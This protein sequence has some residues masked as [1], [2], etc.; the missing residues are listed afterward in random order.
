MLK[1]TTLYTVLLGSLLIP[2]LSF[3]ADD[4]VEDIHQLTLQWT[5][6]EH[7]KDLLRKNWRGDKPVLEQQLSLL[8]RET[9]AQAGHPV[10]RGDERVGPPSAA[11][12]A[13]QPRGGM[14]RG[15]TPARWS[16]LAASPLRA[17]LGRAPGG[18]A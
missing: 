6:L 18:T 10:R 12:N 5:G 3:G 16:R 8:E 4:P 7:Q 13:N 14:A 15:L 11:P 9:R 2:M 17:F 1:N